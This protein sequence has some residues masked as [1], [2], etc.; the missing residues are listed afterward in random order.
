MVAM[1]FLFDA[2]KGETPES[3][4]RMR[5]IAEMLAGR[6]RS[7]QTIGDG[8]V[9][10]GDGIGAAINRHRANKAEREG[11]AGANALFGGL[12]FSSLYGGGGEG[13]VSA[14]VGP[15][16][17]S[18]AGGARAASDI[19]PMRSDKTDIASLASY[20]QEAASARGI[21]PN[22]ALR[23][24]R[25]EGLAPGVWQSNVVKNGRRETSYG[26]FQLLVG[27]G[28]GD[29]FQKLYG[30]SPA[31][32]STVYDQ[33]DFALDEAATGGW[34]PWYGAAKVGVGNRT[35][36]ERARALGV[37]RTDTRT[38]GA[39]NA[40]VASL[41]PDVGMADA[42]LP[43]QP[44]PVSPAAPKPTISAAA[45]AQAAPVQLAQSGSNRAVIEKL[46]QAGQNPWLN[47]SQRAM[48]NALLQRELQKSDPAF[49]QEQ[50]AKR[51]Q[52]DLHRAQTGDIATD[53]QREA[54]KLGLD[55][56]RFGLDKTKAEQ[57]QAERDRRF[58]LDS[59][60]FDSESA[61]RTADNT[62]AD[63]E[64]EMKMQQAGMT[65]DLREYQFYADQEK[66]AGR[67]PIGLREFMAEMKKAGAASTSVTLK[68]ETKYDE[69]VGEGYGKRFLDMQGEAQSAQSTLGTLT[70]MEGL[71][72]Q[73]G[74]Y[75]GWGSGPV[76]DLK[77]MGAAIGLDPEGID[78]IES[79]NALA[80]QAA[81]NNMGG[82]LGTGF[83]NADRD[84]VT[85]Q[86]PGLQNTPEGNKR[87]IEITRKINERKLQVA[88]LARKY[89][90]RNGGRIDAGFDDYLSN[91]AADNPLFEQKAPPPP[92]PDK[93]V[94]DWTDEELEQY[95]NA[96]P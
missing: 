89:A 58:G 47:D 92:I 27:G 56:E 65:D 62:R 31:D 43:E 4:A 74:F 59:R 53:N 81:L 25:S 20:I 78:S 33:I 51:L 21:D 85:D 26:P 91:W 5:R 60:K 77:R 50:E 10:L 40:R 71:L 11:R 80:K 69:T 52:M 36:L 32:P 3:V 72:S 29:K 82:S 63:R 46:M 42:G 75:S 61:D 16:A 70:A 15:K 39:P 1:P 86:V 44:A 14:L 12:D 34:G 88:D 49:L 87:L 76:T 83:S 18:P 2:T 38:S 19:Q 41:D 94:S 96:Q 45:P 84:F 24:A 8:L 9:A 68:G 28:L 13:V 95:L 79:F 17:D 73:P 22:V 66:A 64:L 35:G 48:I 7:P 23:V 57:E 54:E 90:A 67:E 30:K 37:S 93:P 55:R 6:G